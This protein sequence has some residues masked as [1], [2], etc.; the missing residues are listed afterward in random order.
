MKAIIEFNLDE[1]DDVEEHK[2]FTNMNA[3]YLA[4]WE[5]DEV[6]R[7]QVKYNTQGYTAEQVEA[8]HELREKFYQILNENQIKID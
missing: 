2:R 5:F 6:M 4:L 7:Q 8:I 3:V 1:P